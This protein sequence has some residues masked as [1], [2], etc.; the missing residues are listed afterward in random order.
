MLLLLFPSLLPSAPHLTSYHI[1]SWHLMASHLQHLFYPSSISLLP[2]T[3][4]QP[5]TDASIQRLIDGTG[6]LFVPLSAVCCLLLLAAFLVTQLHFIH[7]SSPASALSL[8]LSL[9]VSVWLVHLCLCLSLCLCFSLVSLLISLSPYRLRLR[10]SIVCFF[11]S[12]PFP[13]PDLLKN[14]LL[15]PLT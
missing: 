5:S 14:T 4:H 11:L 1:M 13:R 7:P 9:A 8:P 10:G 12:D 6:L 2:L 15:H 3:H